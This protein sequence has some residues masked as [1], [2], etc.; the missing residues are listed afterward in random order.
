MSK[1]G[2]RR[3]LLMIAMSLVFSMSAYATEI[4]VGNPIDQDGS[5]VTTRA[6]QVRWYY[7][8]H[9]GVKQKRLWSI[10]YGYWKTKWM[11]V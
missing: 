2:M 7:R 4:P 9:N 3:V 10:T 11:K 8:I 1:R 6:E 5:Q